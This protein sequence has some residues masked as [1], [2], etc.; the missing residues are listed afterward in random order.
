[1][2]TGRSLSSGRPKAGPVGRCDKKGE[3]IF[4]I[5][6]ENREAKMLPPLRDLPFSVAQF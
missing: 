3:V 1:M 2:G 5:D 4:M 6:T